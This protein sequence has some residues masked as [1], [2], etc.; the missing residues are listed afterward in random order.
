MQVN[1]ILAADFYKIGH[2]FQ[3]PKGTT[4]IYSN[5]TPRSNRLGV[6]DKV[7]NFGLQ[8]FILDFLMVSFNNNFFALPKSAVIAEYNRRNDGA[9]GPGSV[10]SSHIAALHDL[11]YLPLEIKALPEGALVGMKV[12]LL[13][14][15]NTLPEFFWLTNYIETALSAELWKPVTTATT[16][17]E[18]RKLLQSFAVKTGSPLDFVLWQGHDFSMRGQSS[19]EDAAKSGAGH[20][21]SF[22]GTDTIPAIQRIEQSYGGLQTF[23]GGSVPATEHAVMCAGGFDDEQETIR[24]IVQDV[25]PTGVVSVVSDTWDFWNTISVKAKNLK[26]VILNRQPNALGLAKTVFRP[27]S[28]DPVEVLCGIEIETVDSILEAAEILYDRE[29]ETT[30]HGECG[31]WDVSGYFR[32]E[33]KIFKVTAVIDWNRHDKQ[34]YF[35]EGF[36]VKSYVEVELT[37]EQKGAVEVLWDIFGGTITATGHKLLNER[38]GLI[39]GDS[40]TLERANNILTRL[41]AKGFCSGNVVFGIG[42]FT[43]QYVTRDTYGFAMKATH[44]IVNG[45]NRPLFKDPKTDNGT[46]KSARGYLRVELENG[47]Y[48]MYDNQTFE[49]S[50]QG[51]LKTVFLNGKLTDFQT[52]DMIRSR[53]NATL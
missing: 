16:A 42:S 2:P 23:V 17:Y 52:I 44:A 19:V 8:G 40:I 34:Y 46:K 33:G 5:F 18:Y 10:D 7:V 32:Y 31:D 21:T 15:R 11:G 36:Q 3:Y 35:A 43:Y 29:L 38:V 4:E 41:E 13:T 50:Q 14:V 53:I 37:P 6:A 9:L 26:E 24:R 49:Q 20:L 25:Y 1:P 27:D 48:V 22:L 45:E 51:E 47:E 12:P 28:G 39:Y 30:A